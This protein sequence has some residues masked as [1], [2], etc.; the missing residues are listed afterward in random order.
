MGY[1]SVTT[2]P[3]KTGAVSSR[4]PTS[5]LKGSNVNPT[6]RHAE[7]YIKQ[8]WPCV[9]VLKGSKKPA[10]TW[11][12]L[13]TRI[14]TPE[15]V[16]EM[17]GTNGVNLSIVTG[18]FS[19]LVVLDADSEKGRDKI[20]SFLPDS[21]QTP[22]CKTAHG[23]HYYFKH[24]G[25][26]IKTGTIIPKHLDCRGDGG[27]IAAPPSEGKEWQVKPSDCKPAHM[28]TSLLEYL[29]EYSLNSS[30]SLYT[31]NKLVTS[32]S[33]LSFVKGARDHTLFRVARHLRQGGCSEA[34]ACQI[35]VNLGKTCDP[36]FSEKECLEKVYSTYRHGQ[37]IHD[38]IA[39]AV[40]EWV[41]VTPGYFLV[42]D[43]YKELELVTSSDKNTAR[44]ALKRMVEDGTIRRT[45]NRGVYEVINKEFQ[46]LDWQNAS[47][48]DE[49]EIRWPLNL[50]NKAIIYPGNLV[51]ISGE[52]NVGKTAFMIALAYMNKDKHDIYYWASSDESDE[53]TL[54][55]RIDK[56]EDPGADWSRFHARKRAHKFCDVIEPDAVN[57]ID[58]ISPYEKPW[59]IAKDLEEIAE[60]IRSGVVIAAIQ[61]DPK[62]ERGVGGE[63]TQFKPAFAFNLIRGDIKTGKPHTLEPTKIKN[64][65]YPDLYKECNSPIKFKLYNG[66]Q[67]FMVGD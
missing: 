64:A 25:E 58:Y 24:P 33:G 30:S 51:L 45:E 8:G 32:P 34:D 38:N 49:L 37:A 19:G 3:S 11:K 62:K 36:P 55:M 23:W 29:R 6:I 42:T 1:S 9:P 50:E 60:K 39:Q 20:E 12:E 56:L 54:K 67:F 46:D 13:Q 15:E 21:Y 28:P 65:R 48:L 10:I 31:S 16:Q 4:G 66:C 57:L 47:D 44:V 22:I 59:M 35:I 14:N 40:R 43:C 52:T 5:S 17:F 26:P 61:K 7:W 2:K 63:F 18:K 53:S 27:L 41:L